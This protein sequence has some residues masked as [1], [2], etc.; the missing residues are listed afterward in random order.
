MGFR[1][2]RRREL[3]SGFRIRNDQSFASCKVSLSISGP[4]GKLG[5]GQAVPAG[6]QCPAW[7]PSTPAR[8]PPTPNPKPPVAPP[9][10]CPGAPRAWG[11]KTP[12]A[13]SPFLLSSAEVELS[14]TSAPWSFTFCFAP[15][16]AGGGRRALSSPQLLPELLEELPENPCW[17][18]RAVAAGKGTAPAEAP[19]NCCLCLM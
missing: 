17:E 19:G 10:G 8:D 9:A 1:Y 11:S 3:N 6:W 18:C 5:Q 16:G 7:A 13:D 15:S 14:P 2:N 4:P 12:F